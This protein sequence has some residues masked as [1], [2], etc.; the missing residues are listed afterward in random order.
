MKVSVL[1]PTYRRP[2]D[3]LKCLQALA[4]QEMPATEVLVV[5]R[6]DDQDTHDALELLPAPCVS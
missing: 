3:L 2:T 5:C 4:M 6:T 1:V